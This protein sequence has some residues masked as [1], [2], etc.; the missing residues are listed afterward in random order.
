MVSVSFWSLLSH[1]RVRA[2]NSS[3]LRTRRY[4]SSSARTFAVSPVDGCIDASKELDA[5]QI[6]SVLDCCSRPGVDRDQYPDKTVS[7]EARVKWLLG[8]LLYRVDAWRI[9]SHHF[10]RHAGRHM[11]MASRS[12]KG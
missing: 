7:V 11:E 4:Y 9:C 1:V 3:V 6:N 8:Y 2:T 10:S 5:A 12:K